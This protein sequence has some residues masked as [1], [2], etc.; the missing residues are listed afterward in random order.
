[1]ILEYKLIYPAHAL[2]YEK[3]FLEQLHTSNLQG[4]LSREGLELRLFV[5]AEEPQ[6]LDAFATDFAMRLPHSLFL[7]GTE[8]RLVE[9][10]PTIPY[11]LVE[12]KKIPLPPCPACLNSLKERYDIFTAC[13]WCGYAV[14]AGSGVYQEQFEHTA[15]KIEEG[16]IVELNTLYG[17]YFVGRPSSLCN[18]VSFDILAYDLATVE[19]YATV[20]SYE[21]N[22]LASLEKPAITLKKRLQFTRDF[23]A[24][25]ADLMRFRLPDDAILYLLMEALHQRGVDII[26]MTKARVHAQEQLLLTPIVEEL[27]PLEVVASP[28]HTLI[29]SGDRGVPPTPLLMPKL[30][31]QIDAF[32]AI[33]EQ[34]NL[35]QSAQTI[36]GVNLDRSGINIV[37]QGEKFGLIEY[38]A[39][40]CRF[41]SIE[42]IFQKISLSDEAGEKLVENYQTHFSQHYE[43]IKSMQLE[44]WDGFYS[45]WGVIAIILGFTS[46]DNLHE[47]AK[48]IEENALNFLGDRGPRI[49]YKLVNLEGK[50]SFDPLMTIRTAMS[51]K[52]AGVDPLGLSYGVIESFLEFVTNEL[53]GLKESMAIDAV[54]V[55]GSL[56][57]N[58]RI[59]VKI[60]QEVSMNHRLYFSQSVERVAV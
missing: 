59:F 37:V 7:Y 8:A 41:E 16:A 10:M 25:E 33:I 53:D 34:W 50:P 15:Q 26:F 38:L 46:T 20:E 55:R 6:A 30:T 57:A 19:K 5:E 23:E 40:G 22:A 52:L 42:E 45:L 47:G 4:N 14:E 54:V 21:L 27:T 13:D 51:F 49:D 18:E 28:N 44:Q 11:P 48:R 2:V 56:L 29:L 60:S 36:A 58:R 9:E 32:H 39:F 12:E 43:A 24:V 17:K 35:S 1:M 3:I 31:P